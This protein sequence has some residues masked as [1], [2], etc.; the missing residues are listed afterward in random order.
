MA[1]ADTATTT[2]LPN[3]VSGARLV[4]SFGDPRSGGRTHAGID[5][6]APAGSRISS[7]VEGTVEVAGNDRGAGG[8]RVWIRARDGFFYYFAHLR[9]IAVTVGQ[10]IGIG[11]TIGTVGNTGN[12][13]GGAPH[14]HLSV[15]ERVGREQPIANPYDLLTGRLDAGTFDVDRNGRLSINEAQ[16]GASWLRA[17]DPNNPALPGQ[18]WSIT[19]VVPDI[20][21]VG[22]VAGAVGDALGLDDLAS[23]AWGLFVRTGLVIA[24]FVLI[25]V[26]VLIAARQTDTGAALE[27]NAGKAAAGA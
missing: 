6:M 27:N 4:D 1:S 11:D 23:G 22:D 5:I 17:H 19:D 15:N 9:D 21:S 13:A 12:A 7:P 25:V 18:Q 26:A 10:R 20:P 16:T 24:G 14:L 3:P 2:P 8:N